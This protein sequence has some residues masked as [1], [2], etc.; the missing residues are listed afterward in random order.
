MNVKEF[1]P[2]AIIGRG[3]F[4]EV[5]LCKYRETGEIFAVKKMKKSEMKL[6]NQIISIT[7]EKELLV[8]AKNNWIV[9][10]NFSFQDD[11]FLY[12]V[13]EYL[14]G[15]D[16]MNLLIIKNIFTEDEARFYAAELVLA[17][18]YVHKLNYIHR[19][20]KP[21]NVLIDKYGHLKLSDFG[22]SKKMVL[23]NPKQDI[24]LSNDLSSNLIS[25]QNNFNQTL[26]HKNKRNVFLDVN[27]IACFLNCGKP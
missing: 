8:E 13:M 26:N 27:I 17:I 4:G 20:I 1:D 25:K 14:H 24:H 22:L 5:R 12:L 10:L 6:K 2:L 3:A 15:G 9:C 23:I 21:D 16:L 19:D 11:E 7:A 18:E